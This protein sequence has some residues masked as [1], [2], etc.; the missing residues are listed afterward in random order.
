MEMGLVWLAL[1]VAAGVLGAGALRRWPRV[2]V[3]PGEI[4]LEYRDGRLSRQLGPGRY[5]RPAMKGDWRVRVLPAHGFAGYATQINVITAD[6]FAFRLTLTPLVEITTP[7]ALIAA[8]PDPWAMAGAMDY[9][10]ALIPHV[11]AA[12]LHA[13]ADLPL[14]AVLVDRAALVAR[15]EAAVR[16][17][18]PG[19][20]VTGLLLTDL[21]MPP[22]IRRMFTEVE[23]ARRDGLAALE[24]ARAETAALRALANAA[25]SL[26]GNPALAQLRVL[27]AMESARGAKTFVLGSAEPAATGGGKG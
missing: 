14:D 21:T 22:E 4:G 11:Q 13:V 17:A 20:T 18:V 25:R 15:I 6:Q 2:P 24:R 7:E 9:T 8:Q 23:R 12:A 1:L 16:D 3:G 10:A 19:L 26:E 27:H 5:W